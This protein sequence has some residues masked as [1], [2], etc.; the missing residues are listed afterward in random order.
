MVEVNIISETSAAAGQNNNSTILSKLDLQLLHLRV[1]PHCQP[2]RLHTKS[3]RSKILV[4]SSKGQHNKKERNSS[5][6]ST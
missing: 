4:E 2:V 6:H 1:T 5:L 3:P